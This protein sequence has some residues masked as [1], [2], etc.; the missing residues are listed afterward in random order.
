MCANDRRSFFGVNRISCLIRQYSYN[1]LFG[2]NK[3]V[4][5]CMSY[6]TVAIYFCFEKYVFNCMSYRLHDKIYIYI[7]AEL[8]NSCGWGHVL[9]SRNSV[10]GHGGQVEG[11]TALVW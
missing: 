9:N 11:P 3:Y 4:F 7:Y 5:N 8:F 10:E 6:Q 1:K 2:V